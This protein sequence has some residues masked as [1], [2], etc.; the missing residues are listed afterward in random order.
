MMNEVHFL[1]LGRIAYG[2]AHKL[3]KKLF[4]ENVD[5]KLANRRNGIPEYTG[6]RNYLLFCEHP[7]VYTMGKSGNDTDLLLSEAM[8][9]EKGAELHYIDRGGGITY[10]G[11]GQLVG[12]PI[13]DLEQPHFFTDV[14]KYMHTLV[15]IICDV[16]AGHG[17][18]GQHM[19]GDTG[20]WIDPDDPRKARKICSLGVRTSRWVT[21]HGFG[22]NV[23]TNLDYFGYINPCGFTDKQMTTLAKE[24]G[25]PV[26]MALVKEQVK[27]H[28]EQNFDVSLSTVADPVVL[29]E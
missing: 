18:Y 19:K 8:L 7:H 21:M 25:H 9:K 6:T 11:P 20:V 16:L 1:D 15:K 23:N 24:L 13:M 27:H 3:Q 12:Y 22:F 28:F 29:K 14:R 5:L 26:D 2:D 10:H 4:G 17:V